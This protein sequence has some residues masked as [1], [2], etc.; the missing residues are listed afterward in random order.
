M[1]RCVWLVLLM[2]ISCYAIAQDSDAVYQSTKKNSYLRRQSTASRN[3]TDKLIKSLEKSDENATAIN[4][5]ALGDANM[6]QEEYADAEHNFKKAIDIYKKQK[7]QT[8]V[9]EL[10]RRLGQAQEMQHKY[11]KAITNYTT[12]AD[13]IK[14]ADAK[15]V[16]EN[17]I[18]RLRSPNNVAQ[19][20]NYLQHNADI[21]QKQG[22][23]EEAAEVYQQIARNNIDAKD[24]SKAKSNLENA[25]QIAQSPQQ[26]TEI[27][28]QLA[29]V[30]AVNHQYDSA[31]SISNKLLQEATHNNDLLQQLE[32]LQQIASYYNQLSNYDSAIWLLENAY[33]LAFTKY[34]TIECSS[35]TQQLTDIYQEQNKSK[36]AT[37]A[38]QRF[39]DN[40]DTLLARDTTLV[41]DKL[42][43]TTQN[44]IKELENDKILQAQIIVNKNRFNYF[45]L[46]SIAAVLLLSALI[47]RSLQAIKYKNKKIAL[48]SLRREM[49]PHF[50][51]NS[52]NSVNQFIAENNEL[53]ANKYLTSYSGLMR[54][55]MENSNKDFVPMS[56]ELEHL[57]KY[58]ALEHLR[59]RE[60]FDYEINVEDG[61]DSE[62]VLVPN[63]LIQ[64]QLE[65]A[66]WHGLRYKEQKGNLLLK[67]QQKQDMI[68]ISIHDDGI[69]IN[70]SK[71]MKTK[72]QKSHQSIG[73]Y[74]TQQ[75]IGL[76][77][78][79]YKSHIAMNT[80]TSD[81]GT[82]VTFSFTKKHKSDVA[83]N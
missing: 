67:I 9:G 53:E 1:K 64:P 77:N 2:L 16:N 23:T 31:I 42:M 45:L 61:I 70:K 11:D 13:N 48:Q 62:A 38:Y 25:I 27:K 55:V 17:D 59:F 18:T 58:L 72:H 20:T 83:K 43:V 32:Q 7:N 71:A 54:N 75:R 12:A 28:K 81:A 4:Y 33:R 44:R 21:L 52:L 15:Q 80:Q 41:D 24:V 73:L 22:K 36:Q 47:F 8:K 57:K 69:G 79:L 78:N 49:N 34:L 19:Q 6:K 26:K 68:I 10:S 46:G 29:E 3:S 37:K 30:L 76:L 14:D 39:L 51:F 66:I 74:N 65:N 60:K 82:T 35:I 50:I 5:E 40:I 63:M 56:I